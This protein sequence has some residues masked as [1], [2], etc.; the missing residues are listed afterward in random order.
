MLLFFY[1]DGFGV[2]LPTKVDMLLYKD[3]KA[4]EW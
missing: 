2:K 3:V 1:K 4:L